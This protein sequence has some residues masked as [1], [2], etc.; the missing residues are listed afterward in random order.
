MPILAR[1]PQC[2]FGLTVRLRPRQE[3]STCASGFGRGFARRL[4][5][6]LLRVPPTHGCPTEGKA[7]NMDR[8]QL[9]PA[10]GLQGS[11]LVPVF[12]EH[13]WARVGTVSAAAPPTLW[14][15]VT[16]CSAACPLLLRSCRVWPVTSR[17]GLR[18]HLPADQAHRPG[19][20]PGHVPLGGS[21]PPARA[22]GRGLLK[23]PGPKLARG[24]MA[25]RKTGARRGA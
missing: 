12:P 24:C 3:N 19:I 6:W 21:T 11:Q 4:L 22:Q 14:P 25:G 17:P 5:S 2:P 16:A 13:V 15:T 20:L 1:V 7:W 23:G 10:C 18:Q 9:L 8:A